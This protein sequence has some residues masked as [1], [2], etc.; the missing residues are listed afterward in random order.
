MGSRT[1]ARAWPRQGLTPFCLTADRQ[2]PAYLSAIFGPRGY[3]VLP[4]PALLPTVL[5]EVLRS[6]VTN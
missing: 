6:L 1:L 2:A 5:V 3:A 4:R